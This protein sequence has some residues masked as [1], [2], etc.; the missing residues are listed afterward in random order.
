MLFESETFSPDAKPFPDWRNETY[1]YCNFE[2]FSDL[3]DPVEGSYLGCEFVGCGWYW[4]L[5][6]CAVLVRVKFE[7]C[8]F[9]GCSFS[10][11]TFVECEFVGCKF[12]DD[13]FEKGCSF[14]ESRWYG[15]TQSNCTGLEGVF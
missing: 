7:N 3:T 6:N 13:S 10:S 2:R 14:D 8:Q 11:C 12:G 15:C 5:F 9:D 4:A 1:H